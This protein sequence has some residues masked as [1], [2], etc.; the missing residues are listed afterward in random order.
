MFKFGLFFWLNK[1]KLVHE[2]LDLLILYPY[3]VNSW[4]KFLTPSQIYEFY[5]KRNVYVIN[6]L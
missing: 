4:L 2:L 5:Y 6:K 3:I 1:L